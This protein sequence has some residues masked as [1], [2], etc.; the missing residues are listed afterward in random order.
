MHSF[1]FFF[2]LF[3]RILI[4][5]QIYAYLLCFVVLLQTLGIRMIIAHAQALFVSQSSR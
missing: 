4:F 2:A 5:S 3:S 1:M